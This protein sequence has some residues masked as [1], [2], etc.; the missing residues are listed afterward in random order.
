MGYFGLC[1]EC[2]SKKENLTLSGFVLQNA[3]TKPYTFAKFI[4]EH[5]LKSIHLNANAPTLAIETS[6]SK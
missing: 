1:C 3:N 6:H 4:K 5:Y 2:N